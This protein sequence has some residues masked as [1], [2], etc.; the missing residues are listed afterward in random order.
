MITGDSESKALLVGKQCGIILDSEIK[1]YHKDNKDN[2]E[3]KKKNYLCM[4]GS[5]LHEFVGG[6]VDKY[7]GEE[8]KVYGK[9]EKREIVANEVKMKKV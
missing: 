5:E 2:K 4:S 7:T 6:I 8:V 1:K 3:G 9:N